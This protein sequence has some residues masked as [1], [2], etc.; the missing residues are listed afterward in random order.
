MEYWSIGVV[1]KWNHGIM[2]DRKQGTGSIIA[3]RKGD[4]KASKAMGLSA[5]DFSH[6]SNIPVFQ[7][8]YTCSRC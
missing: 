5:L 3:S 7:C 4:G 1:E 2:G 6:Y 8:S